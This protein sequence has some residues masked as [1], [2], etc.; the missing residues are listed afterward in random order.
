MYLGMTQEEADASGRFRGTDQG[1]QLKSTTGWTLRPGGLN[2]TNTSGF[3]GRPAGI[4]NWAGSFNGGGSDGHWWTATE[5]TNE[6]NLTLPVTRNLDNSSIQVG[7][8]RGDGRN[9][10]SVRCV[11]D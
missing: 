10:L 4:R 6:S 9:G 1:S 8:G 5:T 3:T 11:K 7:K 2:G